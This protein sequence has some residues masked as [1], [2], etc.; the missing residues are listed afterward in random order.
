MDYKLR[1]DVPIFQQIA[2]TIESG[3]L[4]GSYSIGDRVPSTNEF[5][6]FYQI[7]PATAA[8]GINQLVE[9]EILFKKRGIGM[10]VGDQAREIILSKRKDRF[11]H[12]YIVPLKTEAEK[13]GISESEL[14]TLLRK[15]DPK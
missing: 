15:G 2:E 8:K 14:N 12:D 3:I 10:F 9:Q 4:E 1:E 7:N 6:K 11:Y 5:A 13:L